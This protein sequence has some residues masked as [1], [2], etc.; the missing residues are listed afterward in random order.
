MHLWNEVLKRFRSVQWTELT[1][2]EMLWLSWSNLYNVSPSIHDS[3]FSMYLARILN[4]ITTLS[5]S[6]E[7]KVLSPAQSDCTCITR[8]QDT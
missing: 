5:P 3:L 6:D 2:C 8:N 4:R 7:H 1:L